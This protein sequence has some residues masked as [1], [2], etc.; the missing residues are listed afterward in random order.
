[1]RAIKDKSILPS[2][3]MVDPEDA[4]VLEEC[5]LWE[6]G[7]RLLCVDVSDYIITEVDMRRDVRDR[8]V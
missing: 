6:N 8:K 7:M 3:C 2:A 1:M 5:D 4:V